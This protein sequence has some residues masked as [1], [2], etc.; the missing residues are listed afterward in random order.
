MC[1]L[2]ALGLRASPVDGSHI[3][4]MIYGCLGF[5]HHFGT[6]SLFG[7]WVLVPS[8]LAG[9]HTRYLAKEPWCPKPSAEAEAEPLNPLRSA[10]GNPRRSLIRKAPIAKL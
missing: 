9:Y 6:S 2:G 10:P 1:L 8:H 4:P 7:L 3:N 5:H